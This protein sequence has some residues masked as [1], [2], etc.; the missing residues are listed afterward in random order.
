MLQGLV[1]V[2]LRIGRRAAEDTFDDSVAAA[3]VEKRSIGGA[4]TGH[5]TAVVPVP[6]PNFSRYLVVALVIGR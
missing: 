1:V 6:D 4:A 3:V 2:E 5:P